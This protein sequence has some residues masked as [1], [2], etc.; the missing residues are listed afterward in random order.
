MAADL[1]YKGVYPIG[2]TDPMAMPV[3][4]LDAS[5]DYYE[6][7]MGFRVVTRGTEPEPHA[8]IQRGGV[9]LRLV[10]NGEDPE[11]ASVYFDVTDVETARAELAEAG[12]KVTDL[13]V[14]GE[15]DQRSRVFFS[16]APDGLCFCIGQP[17]G[18]D[19]G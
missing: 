16:R 11:Q 19:N 15:G 4:D 5:V 6:K 13:R 9:T 1:E 7:L 8:V 17:A 12:A 2:E 18:E 10:V 3:R 14:D